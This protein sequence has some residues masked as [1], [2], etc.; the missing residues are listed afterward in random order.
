MSTDL[1][2]LVVDG[3]QGLVLSEPTTEQVTAPRPALA[4]SREE[5]YARLMA[6]DKDFVAASASGTVTAVRADWAQYLG[7]CEATRSPALAC[8]VKQLE[9]FISNAIDRGRKRSTVSRYIYTIGLIHDAAGLPNPVKDG[10]WKMKWKALG[11][12]LRASGGSRVKQAAGITSTG[13]EAMLAIMG[14]SPRDLRD[15]ALLS[16][17]SDTLC[18]ESEL[19]RIQVDDIVHDTENNTWSLT[20]PYSKT[21][22]EGTEEEARYVSKATSERVDA[23][24]T[25]QGITS[26][27]LFLPL[28]GRPKEGATIKQPG[29][30]GKMLVLHVKPEPHLRPQEVARIFRQRAAAAGLKNW[31][32]VSGHSMRVGSASELINDGYTIAQA[33]AA[34]GWKSEAMVVRYTK[35]ARAGRNA[36]A[37][38]RERKAKE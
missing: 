31:S 15:A 5:I 11:K 12:R 30:N 34:G 14:K 35:K 10:T 18:R 23:W 6:W 38:M 8:T 7:W 25:S 37:Q 21:D 27:Y 29:T 20:L 32:G 1:S 19:V 16:L 9:A 24:K 26:G 22:Q 33:M 4:S 3:L 36:M 13:I 17:A 2:M 28:R